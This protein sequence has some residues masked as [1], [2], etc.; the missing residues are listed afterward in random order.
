MGRIIV[1][2]EKILFL[3]GPNNIH[4][5]AFCR[6]AKRLRAFLQ[7]GQITE[8]LFTGTPY[9]G[10]PIGARVDEPP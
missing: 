9:L 5:E 4:I 2:Y 8:G 3:K 7:R 1:R 10:V 6:G